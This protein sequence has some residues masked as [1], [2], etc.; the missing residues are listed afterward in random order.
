MISIVT[1]VYNGE[2]FIEKN[3]NSIMSL[4]IS[5]E[6][7]IVDGGSSDKTLEI[8]AKY[9]HVILIHQN[10]KNGMYGAIHQGFQKA[11]YSWMTWINC[12]DVIVT[13]NFEKV[14]SFAY[15]NTFD[16]IYGDSRFNWEELNKIEFKKSN[17]FAKYFLQKGIMPFVQPSTIYKKSIYDTIQLNFNDF[18][19]IGDLDFFMRIAK[20]N[21]KFHYCNL[22]LTEFLKYGESLGDR[23]NDLYKIEYKNLNI[24]PN[25]LH[26]ILFKLSLKF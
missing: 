1:P 18:K 11:Q 7:I 6:H 21:F 25:L 2:R 23:N 17:P 14:I 26:R 4:G 15:S 22:I 19:I 3:I 5:Y 12:D 20:S 13:E 8:I 9:P 16:F 24:K 10:E